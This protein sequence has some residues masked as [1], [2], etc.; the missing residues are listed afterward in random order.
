MNFINNIFKREAVAATPASDADVTAKGGNYGGREVQ[1]NSSAAALS[2]AAFYRAVE[3]RANTMS[4]LVMEYQKKNDASH[5]GNYEMDVRGYGKRLNYLLQVQPNPTMTWAQLIKQAELQRIF[6]GNAVVFIERDEYAEI[7]ALWLCSSASLITNGKNYKYN[8]TYNAYGGS[9]TKTDVDATDVLHVRNTF[10][11]DYGLTGIPTL[12]YASKALTL[13]ATNDKLVTE[14]AAKG[15]RQKLLVQEDKGN[16]TFGLGRAAKKELEKAANQLQDDLWEKDVVL[17][18]NVASATPISTNLQQAE[19]NALRA[20][21]VREV[22]RFMGTPAIMLM[23]DS[24]SSYKSPEAATQEF[25]LRTISPLGNDWEMEMNAKILGFEGYPT[26]RFHF[27]EESLMR[28]DPLG[29]ANIG[30]VLLETGVKCVNELRA[31]Y[32]LPSVEKGDTH[33]VST[34]LAELGS[35]K[36]SEPASPA[37]ATHKDTQGGEEG[38]SK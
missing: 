17:L 20:F 21:S 19:I 31:D 11:N 8:V 28:L 29:R 13:A 33:Y 38:G 32:D 14:T 12:R 27:N 34:N 26:H 37:G 23:D 6:Q 5:G 22:A 15:M 3:L 24:N 2:V 7:K 30:K 10:S 16:G 4:Q 1:V 35:K 18:S 25:L 36:L 9:V